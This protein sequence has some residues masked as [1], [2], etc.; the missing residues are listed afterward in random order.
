M[1]R[2][3]AIIEKGS[4]GGYGIYCP[5]LDVVLIGNGLTEQE[6]KDELH[7]CLDMIVEHYSENGYELPEALNGG[8]VAFDYHYDFSAFFKAYPVF[9][10]SG[11][12]AAIGINPS[13][14]RKY[15]N[16]HAFASSRQRAKIMKGLHTLSKRLSTVQF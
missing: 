3:K 12:A 10:V 8:D 2:I 15:K 11:L 5:D 1:K 14:M 7:E 16:G 4:D 9:N 6:A 13:L